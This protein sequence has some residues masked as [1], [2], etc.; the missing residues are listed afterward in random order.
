MAQVNLLTNFSSDE[1]RKIFREEIEIALKTQNEKRR[2]S[3]PNGFLTRKTVASLFSI[4]LNTLDKY[5]GLGYLQA[6]EIGSRILFKESEIENSLIPIKNF[7]RLK[8]ND[9]CHS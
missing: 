3:I 8:K 1:L 5:C 9:S 2:E 6:Y 4:S 7:D